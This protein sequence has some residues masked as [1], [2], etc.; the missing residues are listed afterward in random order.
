MLSERSYS[1]QAC[2]TSPSSWR[3]RASTLYL[4]NLMLIHLVKLCCFSLSWDLN[5]YKTGEQSHHSKKKRH[6]PKTTPDTAASDYAL[7]CIQGYKGF[8]SLLP[9]KRTRTKA[10]SQ[11]HVRISKQAIYLNAKICTVHERTRDGRGH[12]LEEPFTTRP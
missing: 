3:V 9:T 10:S 2:I 12:R 7:R 8:F 11:S 4:K 1:S 6:E 5:K